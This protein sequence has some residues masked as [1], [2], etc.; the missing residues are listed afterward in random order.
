MTE[1]HLAKAEQHVAQCAR[2]VGRHRARVVELNDDGRQTS[3]LRKLLQ[4][5]EQLLGSLMRDR[6]RLRAELGQTS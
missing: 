6:D 1:N 4:Q 2:Q 3:D 5:Y